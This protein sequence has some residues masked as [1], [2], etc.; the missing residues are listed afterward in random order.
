MSRSLFLVGTTPYDPAESLERFASVLGPHTRRFPDG[1]QYGWLPNQVFED[2]KDLVPGNDEP[3]SP[4]AITST[5]RPAP[6]TSVEDI[7][8]G[9]IHYATAARA[10][11]EAFRRLKDDGRLAPDARYQMSIPTAFTSC[12]FFDWDVVRGLWPVYERQLFENIAELYAAIPHDEL[13]ISWDVVAEFMLLTGPR[14]REQYTF[15]ELVDGVARAI[16]AVPADV[17]TGLHFC[18][19]GHNSNGDIDTR[20]DVEKEWLTPAL[21]DLRDTELMVEFFSA[22]DARA[23]RPIEWL[24]IPVP[25]QHDD[26][27]Y[28]APLAGLDLGQTELYLGLIHLTDGVEGT[29]RKIA[30]AERHVRNFGVAAACGLGPIVS[31][32]SPDQIPAMIDY[33]RE[34][35]MIDESTASSA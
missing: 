8:F 35:A 23:H 22:I 32:L 28:F 10:G 11:Y 21:R 5:F 3:L 25:R 33:H 4:T 29:A 19:G 18:Y 1:Q 20:S 12:L 13:A 17:E 34:I 6:G 24:H 16:D 9:T 14:P 27:A 30:A 7:R 15:E 26:D 2:T 31:G